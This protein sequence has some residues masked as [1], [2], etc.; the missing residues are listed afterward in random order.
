MAGFRS[1][2][3]T[4]RRWHGR[5]HCAPSS[6]ELKQFWTFKQKGCSF[7]QV[8]DSSLLHSSVCRAGARSIVASCGVYRAY[9]VVEIC[10][11]RHPVVQPSVPFGLDGWEEVHVNQSNH[12][13]TGRNHEVDGRARCKPQIR[14]IRSVHVNKSI[15]WGS[16]DLTNPAA[17]VP[18]SH[19]KYQAAADVPS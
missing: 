13:N 2:P 15:F 9:R 5:A 17:A 19:P 3:A 7:I 18:S 12:V 4:E 10:R 6:S 1:L 16:W 14:Q 11:G 8:F